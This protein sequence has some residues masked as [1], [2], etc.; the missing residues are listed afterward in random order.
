[1]STLLLFYVS[2]RKNPLAT[3]HFAWHAEGLSRIQII[4]VDILG[5]LNGGSLAG[6]DH[7]E[8]YK[9]LEEMEQEKKKLGAVKHFT[10]TTFS[11]LCNS[12]ILCCLRSVDLE[13]GL[14]V[15]RVDHA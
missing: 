13:S 9:Q 10:C 15:L 12:M 14:T 6:V 7:E 5:L 11:L 4:H 1:M 2:L 8:S 3:L